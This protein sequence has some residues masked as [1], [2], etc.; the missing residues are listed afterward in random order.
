MFLAFWK[1]DEQNLFFKLLALNCSAN[2]VA[3][4]KLDPENQ[5]ISTTD[6]SYSHCFYS[7]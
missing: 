2:A 7:F 1:A 5:L 3:E 6:E 4:Y